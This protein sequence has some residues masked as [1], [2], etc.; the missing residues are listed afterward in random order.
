MFVVQW[1]DEKKPSHCCHNK[2]QA[3][4]DWQAATPSIIEYVFR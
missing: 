2:R 1:L 4:P 3:K